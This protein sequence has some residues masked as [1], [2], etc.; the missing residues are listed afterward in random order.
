MRT[1]S[2]LLTCILLFTFIAAFAHAADD[3]KMVPSLNE[4]I[5]S[6]R[7]EHN[8]NNL[9]KHFINKIEVTVNGKLL[10]VQEFLKQRDKNAQEAIY[11]MP[12]LKAGDELVVKATC[13]LGG[14]KSG[15]FKIEEE[16]KEE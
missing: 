1:K 2:I 9:E 6:V 13:N 4:G 11:V 3:I 14:V 15:T 7:V 16:E 10:I 5:F 12:S 8:T